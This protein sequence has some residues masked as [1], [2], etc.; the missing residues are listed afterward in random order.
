[1]GCNVVVCL[2]GDRGITRSSASIQ[3]MKI[4][5]HKDKWFRILPAEVPRYN[6]VLFNIKPFL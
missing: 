3:R 5:A 6:N 4:N 1:M 2:S